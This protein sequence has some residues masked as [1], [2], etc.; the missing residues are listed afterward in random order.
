MPRFKEENSNDSLNSGNSEKSAADG[1]M[2][3]D[4]SQLLSSLQKNFSLNLIFFFF[5]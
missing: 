3:D 2:N 5:I 4:V 1:V